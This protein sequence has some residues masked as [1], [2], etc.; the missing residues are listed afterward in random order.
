MI[1]ND[2]TATVTLMKRLLEEEGY[3]VIFQHEGSLAYPAIQH[4]RPDLVLLDLRLTRPDE[5]W[6]VLEAMKLDRDTTH[7]PVVVC[8]ADRQQLE[9]SSLRLRELN[10]DILEKPFSLDHLLAK[11]RERL[12]S[13]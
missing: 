5:G 7:I 12:A 4:E 13:T 3:S 6:R 2:D 8:S 10:C 11:V 9:A 1:I